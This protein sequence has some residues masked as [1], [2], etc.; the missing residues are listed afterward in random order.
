LSAA[1]SV[2]RIAGADA[3]RVHLGHT[4]L[5][6]ARREGIDVIVRLPHRHD[7]MKSVHRLLRR[8][9]MPGRRETVERKAQRVIELRERVA[10]VTDSVTHVAKQVWPHPIGTKVI[11]TPVDG[12]PIE[13]KTCI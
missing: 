11:Y 8:A 7:V 9:S 2:M 5:V 1:L 4:T 12:E 13:T 6:G 10:K 3:I